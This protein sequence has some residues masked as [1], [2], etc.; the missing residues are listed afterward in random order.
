[1]TDWIRR[2]YEAVK[3]SG[4]ERELAIRIPYSIEGCLSIGLDPVDWIHQ[5]IVD[6]IVGQ[7]FSGPELVDPLTDFGPL[8]SAA[9]GSQ[10]RIHAAIHSHLDS[11]RL[12][13]APIEMIRAIACNYWSQGIDGLFLAHWFSNWP[14]E[15]SFYEKLRELPH[16][17]VMACK[18]KF[19]HIPTATNR[20]ATPPLEPGMTMQLPATL[21]EG[22]SVE[23]SLTISDDLERWDRVNRVHEVLLRCRI[24]GAT[25]LDRFSFSLN[26]AEL[27]DSL[28][29]KINQMYTMASP[30]YRV[31]GYW[32]IYRLDRVNWPRKGDN[33]LQVTLTGRDPDVTPAITLLDVELEIKYLMGKNYHRS[34]VDADLGPYER[35]V[36]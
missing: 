33:K 9:K 34:F 20:Y 19:Y 22:K 21:K 36:E 14:Y 7:A 29:R 24:Q 12:N 1:M 27:P 16:P 25:E 3:K 28:Q 23:L 35:R 11:D 10:T 2:V 8:A 13:E 15:A 31:G 32:F 30:R 5:G 26:G 17:D 4:P 6:V 18:D